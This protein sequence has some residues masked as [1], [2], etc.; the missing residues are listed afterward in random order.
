MDA[1]RH[2]MVSYVLDFCD[3]TLKKLDVIYEGN[4]ISVE[5]I[6]EVVNYT[7]RDLKRISLDLSDKISRQK[8]AAYYGFWFAKLAPISG[9]TRKS[10]EG[11]EIVDINERIAV[12]LALDFDLPPGSSLTLM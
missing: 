8:Y 5:K 7:T 6:V 12:R 9:V 11:Y 10:P 1:L 4:G 3:V 2:P